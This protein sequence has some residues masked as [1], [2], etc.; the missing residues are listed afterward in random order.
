MDM[1]KPGFFGFAPA[2]ERAAIVK[3]TLRFLASGLPFLD[4]DDRRWLA[5]VAEQMEH[6]DPAEATCCPLCE[7]VRCDDGCPLE[8]LRAHLVR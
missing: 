5:D 6:Q 8:P 3:D 4:E 2:S 1:R 7:E